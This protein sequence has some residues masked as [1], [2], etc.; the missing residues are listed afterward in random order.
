MSTISVTRLRLNRW[1]D[2]PA[3]LFHAVRSAIQAKRADGNLGVALRNDGRVHWTMTAWRDPAALRA[4]ML[5]GNHRQAMPKLAGWCDEASLARF[6]HDGRELPSWKTAEGILAAE[7][8]TSKL[9]HPSPAHAA[10]LTLGE[11]GRA[12]AVALGAV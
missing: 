2:W 9:D 12:S 5:S 4:F 8:R 10:G 1:R 7:G 3:F 6:E 11:K